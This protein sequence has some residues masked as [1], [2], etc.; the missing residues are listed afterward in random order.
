VSGEAYVKL[1][2][3]NMGERG[4]EKLFE[5]LIAKFFLKNL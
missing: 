2:F 5:K 3:E 1:E 4:S